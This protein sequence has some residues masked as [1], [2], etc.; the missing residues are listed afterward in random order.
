M[1]HFS[2]QRATIFSGVRCSFKKDGSSPPAAVGAE[3]SC[4]SL[5]LV[6]IR[7]AS[8]SGAPGAEDC[9]IIL[10]NI[11]IIIITTIAIIGI[12]I[13]MV[14]VIVRIPVIYHDYCCYYY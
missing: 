10:L 5:G 2:L 12:T 1:Q 11:L 8:E 6:A 3:S 7:I 14:D 9:F 4:A 13:F